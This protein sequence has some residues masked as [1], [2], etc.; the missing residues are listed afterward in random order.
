VQL[1]LLR[2]RVVMAA[3]KAQ[4]DV[5]LRRL[6]YALPG[7]GAAAERRDAQGK[8]KSGRRRCEPFFYSHPI[9][10]FAAKGG[11]SERCQRRIQRSGSAC[12]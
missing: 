6:H 10:E 7:R 12:A 4:T 9:C 2:Q 1:R 3:Q 5:L 11:V 8:K